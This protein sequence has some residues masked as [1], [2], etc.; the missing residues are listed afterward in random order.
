MVINSER[1][2]LK[3]LTGL[4]N[5][6]LVQ[7]WLKYKGKMQGNNYQLDKEP[8]QKIP[9]I[10]DIDDNI[11]QN[12]IM[13]VDNILQEYESNFEFPKIESLENELNNLIYEL[14]EITED[15]IKLIEESL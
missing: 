14:Y 8:L 7:F 11:E 10:T 9:I 13:L 4:L 2:N 12:V 5:S 15:E 3:F 1:F 6:K